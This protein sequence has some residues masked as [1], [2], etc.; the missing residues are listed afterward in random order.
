[1]IHLLAKDESNFTNLKDYLFFFFFFFFYLVL[2]WSIVNLA[3]ALILW[4]PDANGRLFGKDSKLNQLYIHIYIYTHKHTRSF[5]DSF[6]VLV[7][8]Y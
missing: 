1:M 8:E 4:P 5:L 7:T 3:K 6:P 2:C